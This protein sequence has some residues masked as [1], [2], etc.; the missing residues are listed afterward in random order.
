MPESLSHRHL[1]RELVKYIAKT[2]CKGST[3]A[4][5]IDTEQDEGI[6]RPPVI[7]SHVPDV[8]VN[9]GESVI[10]VIGEAKPAGDIQSRRTLAQYE[11]Y[12]DYASK[13]LNCKIIIAAPWHCVPTIKNTMMNI[14]RRKNSAISYQVI[15]GLGDEPYIG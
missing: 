11:A 3:K 5:A 14:C 12:I 1:V 10:E 2:Y 4:V 8:Y 15:E 13:R 7:N 9:S 6:G